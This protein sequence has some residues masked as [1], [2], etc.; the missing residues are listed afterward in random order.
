VARHG[1]VLDVVALGVRYVVD[2]HAAPHDPPA[3]R[4]VVDAVLLDV[5]RVR[6]LIVLEV[7]VV[8]ARL[9]LGPVA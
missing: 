7:V 1:R 4:P 8:Q 5:R 3:L 2:Q 9:L 6:D